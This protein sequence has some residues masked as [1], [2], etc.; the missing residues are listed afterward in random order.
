MAVMVLQNHVD[1]ETRR[2][3]LDK[4]LQRI[5]AVITKLHLFKMSYTQTR[6][7]KI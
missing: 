7:Y 6:I 4:D 1:V 2:E 3:V 5:T